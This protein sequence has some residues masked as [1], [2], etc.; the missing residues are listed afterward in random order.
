MVI[1][2]AWLVSE[3]G[4]NFVK[5]ILA[6]ARQ[7]AAAG[8]PLLVVDDQTGSPTYAGHLAAAVDE[9]LRLGVGPGLY[10][11][12]G[13]ATARGAR[14]RA[15]SSLSPAST[16]RSSPSPRTA[17]PAGAPAAPSR[18]WR[19]S[20]PS[21]ACRTG[22][23][24]SPRRS[25][26]SSRWGRLA[27]VHG[28][29][30][31]RAHRRHRRGRV[32][33]LRLRPPPAARAR[34]RRGRQPRQAHLRR[35]PRQP[36]RR[37]GRP[38]LHAS[39]AATSATPAS[40]RSALAGADAVVNFA[41]ETHVDRSISDPEAFIRT[42]VLGTHTLLEAVRELGVGRFLQ[43]STDE[44]YG[45]I[46]EGSFTEDRP[47]DPRAPTRPARP[48]GDLQVLAYHR[49]YGAPVV[50]TRGS[51]N[52]GPYQYPE[53]LIPLF[54]TNA[55]EDQPLPLYGDGLNVRDWLHVED[56]CAAIE[57]VL[58]EG[59]P[60][61]VY[62]I[63]GGN[64]VANIDLTG[65]SSPSSGKDEGLDHAGRRP[66]RPR[67]PLLGRLR[68]TACP[69]LAPRASPSTRASPRRSPG[70]ATTA[71]GGSASSPAS[72]A[73]T[74]SASTRGSSRASLFAACRSPRPPSGCSTPACPTGTRG[75]SQVICALVRRV[76]PCENA[77]GKRPAA[78]AGWCRGCRSRRSR[79]QLVGAHEPARVCLPCV[80]LEV[81][82]GRRRRGL[83]E[84]AGPAPDKPP[85]LVVVEP[86]LGV[87]DHDVVGIG[88]RDAVRVRVVDDDAPRRGDGERVFGVGRHPD[89]EVLEA[90]ARRLEGHVERRRPRPASRS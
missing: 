81:A 24:A 34:R 65:A 11:M 67:P 47:V 5:T 6:A 82:L 73:P 51:N 71:P 45:S 46:D 83:A 13:A 53:K 56:H 35:Q 64:E 3:T 40:V 48:G 39:C 59:E 31:P 44:V 30:G 55:L 32:H 68:Q 49:T 69:R 20:A 79:Q 85:V 23:T 4:R 72:G 1:R 86:E 33:R 19:P 70:T 7:K 16:S 66:S 77:R 90:R 50:I 17:G 25:T 37:R 80:D 84:H 18:R 2:T 14:S 36:A 42:D 61:Q 21:R 52:Y 58:R 10:H 43:V 22:P 26:G 62:N 12:A 74:T 41:A 75:Y 76:Q 87:V 89:A 15:R 29:G 63:G 60:G 28:R 54:V 8:E 9:A 88:E 57:L 78:T 38:A 27:P